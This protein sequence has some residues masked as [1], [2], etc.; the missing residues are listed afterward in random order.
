VGGACREG[1]DDERGPGF[2]PSKVDAE[3]VVDAAA[4]RRDPFIERV[5]QVCPVVEA[6]GYCQW[7]RVEEICQLP[8]AWG[9]SAWA[10][11]TA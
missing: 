7:T 10:S 6:E 2:R 1:E 4:Y 8:G 5:A 9:S 11:P 3:G